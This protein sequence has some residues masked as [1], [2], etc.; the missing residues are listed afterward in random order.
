MFKKMKDIALS[1][2]A[3][4]AINSQI[5]DFGEILKLNLNSTEKSI[6]MEVMLDGEHDNISIDIKNYEIVE[7]NNQHFLKVN[8]VTTSRAWINSVASSYLEGKAFEI[9]EEY[10]KI[11]KVIA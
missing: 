2:G 8:G 10:A 7:D 3:K 9:S 6:Y 4:V 5:S 11:L 1:N